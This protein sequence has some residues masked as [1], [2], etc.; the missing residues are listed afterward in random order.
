MNIYELEAKTPD[1][2]VIRLKDYSGK[3]ILIVNTATKCGF[4]PQ[5]LGLQKLHQKYKN[6]GLMIIGFPCNQFLQQEPESNATMKETCKTNYGITFQLTEKVDVNG[7]N[8]H[9]VFRYLKSELGGML[10]KKIKW[11]FTKFLISSDGTPVKRY[12]PS[13]K[14]EMFEADIQELLQK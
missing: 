14:P 8:A 3:V 6:Q 10:G 13:T 5:F 9:P 4:T 1:G 12:S 2:K 7:K 11:N